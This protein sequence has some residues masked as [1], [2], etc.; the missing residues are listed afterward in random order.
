MSEP[1][2][3]VLEREILADAVEGTYLIEI[4]DDVGDTGLSVEEYRLRVGEILRRFVADGLIEVSAG[5]WGAQETLPVADDEL[6]RRLDDGSAW[7]K[8]RDDLIVIDATA[9]GRRAM[10]VA[11]A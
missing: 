2:F 6:R 4:S 7:D 9:D 10:G 3:S 11:P 8:D 5:A 1:D